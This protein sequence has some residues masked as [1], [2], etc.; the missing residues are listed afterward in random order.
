MQDQ[1]KDIFGE[2]NDTEAPKDAAD[3][4]KQLYH[5]PADSTVEWFAAKNVFAKPK[6][7]KD[8]TVSLF[9][10]FLSWQIKA[11]NQA[12]YEGSGV[13]TPGTLRNQL[14]VRY[15]PI[16]EGYGDG[17]L[18]GRI[19]CKIQFGETCR[20]CGEKTRAEKRFPR[21]SQPADYFKKVIAAFKS[22]DKTVMLGEVWAQGDG[23]V[24]EKSEKI[25]MF[26]FANY[27]KN[28]RP[29]VQILNDRS[30]D[31]D[32]RI[33][34]DKK[35]YAGYVAPVVLKVT[36]SW[37]TKNGVPEHGQ[38]STWTPTDVTPFPVEA[39]GPDVGPTMF[40]KEWAK[41]V[42]QNDPASWINRTAFSKLD[43][44]DAGRWVYDVFTGK[45]SAAPKL[46]LDTAEFGQLLDV[47][48]KNKEKFDAAGVD[49]N[50]YSYDMVEVLRPIIKG[51]LHG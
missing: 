14:V 24:W 43:A 16:P 29:F 33:R 8:C 11:E 34:I 30:N 40:S 18:S 32:K 9:V 4:T 37:P 23:G 5:L 22:K 45:E 27:L 10:R 38:Y 46:D 49:A 50:E 36:F 44:A 6:T 17:E 1:D 15:H 47:I 41:A 3:P 28:G 12:V 51:V 42:A 19:P 20:W 35:S 25:Q 21:D 39:G 2:V 26:E 48:A 7:L 13:A 31:A